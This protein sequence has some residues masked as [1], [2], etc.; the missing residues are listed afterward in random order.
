[1]NRIVQNI[2]LYNLAY[3]LAWKHISERQK[4]EYPDV[5]MLL[6]DAIRRQLKEGAVEPDLIA[7]EALTYI[8]KPTGQFHSDEEPAVLAD[9]RKNRLRRA[10]RFATG[11]RVPKRMKQRRDKAARF[12]GGNS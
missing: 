10:L 8:E 2:E 3:R 6:H 11:L 5:A 1:M 4:R 12:A 7:S 9:D